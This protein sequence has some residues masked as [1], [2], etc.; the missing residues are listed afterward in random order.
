MEKR[1][2][3][4][5]LTQGKA[6]AVVRPRAGERDEIRVGRIKNISAN[7][8]A[9]EYPSDADFGQE[10][11]YVDVFIPPNRFHLSKVRCKVVYDIRIRGAYVNSVFISS[12]VTKQCGLQFEGLSED[13]M[14]QLNLLIRRNTDVPR[15]RVVVDELIVRKYRETSP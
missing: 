3:L 8:L 11:S 6:V 5:F 4:R 1:R 10:P 13:K 14:S 15:P 2:Y 12:Y 9:L 7:G